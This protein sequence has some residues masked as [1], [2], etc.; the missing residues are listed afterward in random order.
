VNFIWLFWCSTNLHKVSASILGGISQGSAVNQ[1]HVHDGGNIQFGEATF[2]SYLQW[3]TE[4]DRRRV[5][6]TSTDTVAC[7]GNIN[8]SLSTTRSD[9]AYKECLRCLLSSLAHDPVE[10]RSSLLSNNGVKGNVLESTCERIVESKEYADWISNDC[11][12]L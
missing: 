2:I 7:L 5:C 1:G 12:L 3:S 10:Y 8:N 6:G 4:T 11:Q 9:S